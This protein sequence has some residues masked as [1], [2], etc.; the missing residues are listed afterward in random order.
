MKLADEARALNDDDA[1]TLEQ[2]ATAIFGVT[3]LLY[4]AAIVGLSLRGWL[5]RAGLASLAISTFPLV[6][7]AMFTDSDAAG[8]GVLLIF[9][10]PAPLL[11]MALGMVGA[12]VR[13]IRRLRRRAAG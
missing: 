10:I 12:S 8:F 5:F 2:Q 9:M 6:W 11:L 3:I 13:A 7:Q 4:G 1:M